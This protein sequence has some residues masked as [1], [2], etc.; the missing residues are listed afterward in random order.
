MC[1]VF[2]MLAPHVVLPYLTSSLRP[3]MAGF[4]SDVC[5][6]PLMA[7]G[8]SFC[9]SPPYLARACCCLCDP[10][11]GSSRVDSPCDSPVFAHKGTACLVFFFVFVAVA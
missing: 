6:S 1:S 2:C 9:C 5:P 7:E 10:R 8:L 11:P 4:L 3:H